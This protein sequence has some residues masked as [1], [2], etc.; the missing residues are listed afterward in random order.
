MQ[1]TKNCA[2]RCE[3]IV[4]LDVKPHNTCFCSLRNKN[5]ALEWC[6]SFLGGGMYWSCISKG[7]VQPSSTRAACVIAVWTRQEADITQD[8]LRVLLCGSCVCHTQR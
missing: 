2:G 8:G 7:V 1:L 3:I 4:I 6:R 5:A